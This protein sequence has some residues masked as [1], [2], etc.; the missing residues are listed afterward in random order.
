MQAT[1]DFAY[2]HPVWVVFRPY[3]LVTKTHMRPAIFAHKCPI[4]N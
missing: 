2:L 4:Q 1:A 3:S